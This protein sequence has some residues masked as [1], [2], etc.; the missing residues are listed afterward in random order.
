M[1]STSNADSTRSE[2]NADPPTDKP[3]Y[4][5]PV[6]MALTGVPIG[7]GKA[8][9]SGAG[10]NTNCVPGSVADGQQCNEGSS[11]IGSKCNTGPTAVNACDP[12]STA[13]SGCNAG[14]G[15]S[16]SG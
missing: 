11:A 8:C 2:T 14:A 6:V 15:V 9:A 5:M 3:P 16:F 7:A 10:A 12:G 1:Q 13:G 4:E